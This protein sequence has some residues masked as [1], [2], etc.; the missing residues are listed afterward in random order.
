MAYNAPVHKNKNK[1]GYVGIE[2][3][4]SVYKTDG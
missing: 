1:V 3:P 2:S 4:I